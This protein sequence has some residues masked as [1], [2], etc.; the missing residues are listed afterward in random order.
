MQMKLPLQL[1][2]RNISH[3]AELEALVNDRAAEL[4]AFFDRITAC[5][6][7]VELPHHHHARGNRVHVHI[8]L[9]IPGEAIVVTHDPSL[10][11]AL[12]DERE[13]RHSKET[14][15][16]SIHRYA[17]VAIHEAFDAARRQLQDV[18]RRRREPVKSPEPMVS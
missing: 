1:T 13:S 9:A 18:V 17:R 12:R 15:T 2:F 11:G 5:R 3:S 10:H 16:N 7:V 4:E 14:G 6:V 8:E